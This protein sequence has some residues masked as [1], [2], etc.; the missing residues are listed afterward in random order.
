MKK[1]KEFNFETATR[2]PRY[3]RN[4]VKVQKTF[5][6][7]YNIFEW[8]LKERE[9]TGVP[10]QTFVNSVLKM[11]MEGSLVPKTPEIE[12]VR[13]SK[14]RVKRPEKKQAS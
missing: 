8:L 3:D 6:I 12:A 9:R 13:S 7:D 2:G 4:K 10:Y 5:R 1:I 14:A 11:Y